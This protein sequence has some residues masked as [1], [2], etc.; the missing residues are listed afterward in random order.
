MTG[1]RV[2]DLDKTFGDLNVLSGVDLHAPDGSLTAVLGPSG[3][4]KSTLLRIIAGF[5]SPD[6]GLVEIGGTR[7]Y[8]DGKDL[9]PEKRRI[10][11]VPQEG[12]LFPHLSVARNVAFGLPRK[13]SGSGR[14]EEMLEL[15]GM[16]GLGGRMPHELSG[17]QQ[18]RVALARA[19]ASSPSLILMDEP[20]NALDAGLRTKLREDVRTVLSEAGATAILVTHDQ[21]E[22]LSVTD[23]VAVLREG[24]L[25]QTADPATL[26]NS[27]TDLDVA[28]F[29][30]EAVLLPARMRNGLAECALGSLPVRNPHPDTDKGTVMIRPE[31]LLLGPSGQ[32]VVARVLDTT[33][34]GHD[35]LVRLELLEGGAGKTEVLARTAGSIVHS[36]AEVVGVR[37][38]GEVSLYN[39][40]R[41]VR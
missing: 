35:A 12:A 40:L 3:S 38:A 2:T 33:Y 18:Q 24:K 32:G 41:P 23:F 29:L 6:R 25:V 28:T 1:L 4:G 31:Q 13:A 20:F 34:F 36:P 10:G 19:L 15:T 27:P 9:P 5:E 21:Q 17:G 8:G 37:V 16:A 11:F 39:G 30:G 7:V 26:Y 22:A 14:V